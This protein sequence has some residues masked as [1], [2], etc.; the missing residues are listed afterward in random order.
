MNQIRNVKLKQSRLNVTTKTRIRNFYFILIALL[1]LIIASSIYV[2]IEL[3]RDMLNLQ[4]Q[5]LAKYAQ[6]LEQNI[7]NPIMLNIEQAAV[8]IKNSNTNNVDYMQSSLNTIIS[9]RT[10]FVRYIDIMKAIPGTNQYLEIT[11][12][13]KTKKKYEDLNYYDLIK[14][15]NKNKIAH[16][17]GF[18]YTKLEA[19]R[20]NL[21]LSTLVPILVE[22]NT[23]SDEN[24][25]MVIIVFD[26]TDILD[27]FGTDF[28]FYSLG[29]KVDLLVEIYDKDFKL[30]E[31]SKNLQKVKYPLLNRNNNLKKSINY[32]GKLG[33][34]SLTDSKL[35][36][37][38]AFNYEVGLYFS[39]SVPIDYITKAS[40]KFV[41]FILFVG[42]LCVLVA[43][44]II[45]FVFG[46]EDEYRK[47]EIKEV[48]AKFDSLQARMNPH[49]LFNSLDSVSY[50]I[51]ENNYSDATKC[52]RSLSYILRF[53]LRDTGKLMPLTT[54]I[55]YI[56]SY[57]N[58][59]EI[60]Y[61]NRFSFNFDFKINEE[62]ELENLHILKYCI[63]PLVENCF[64]HVIYKESEFI[65]V[66]VCYE[67]N[68]DTLFVNVSNDG[69]SIHADTIYEL[70]QML[71]APIDSHYIE[72]RGMHLGLN[73][74][75]QRIKILF[76]DKYGLKLL[77]CDSG[78]SI[79]A[80]FPLYPKNILTNDNI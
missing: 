73:N 36:T 69:P 40:N 33:L 43:Y 28:S 46:V 63:Q 55:R 74:I 80:I 20:D 2:K 44:I 64:K 61:H 30:L 3:S 77:K 57:I 18:S 14:N 27:Y 25:D 26:I 5:F 41:Y 48:E 9:K 29:Q 15:K 79:Q 45:K 56:R 16:P 12:F 53:D 6:N 7:S 4:Q 52:L 23:T 22:L 60:R 72:Q 38:L 75:N 19:F 17:N 78:F 67:N 59:Q 24:N 58:L 70:N 47:Y 49:F 32:Y 71:T 68:K 51:E 1:L 10:N 65:N 62:I 11:P 31:T 50:A 66:C 42:L 39:I 34:F 76:G 54:Q 21:G 13:K 37:M 35:Q 8:I